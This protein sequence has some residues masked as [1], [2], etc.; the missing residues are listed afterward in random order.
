MELTLQDLR[1]YAIERRV[2]INAT[3]SG[4]GRAVVINTSGQVRIP[5]EDKLFRVES[6]LESADRFEVAGGDRRRQLSR[7]SLAGELSEYFGK[8]VMST[9]HDEDE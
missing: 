6:V 5:G 1:R 8:N 7:Q 9:H 2:E 4:S 3:D